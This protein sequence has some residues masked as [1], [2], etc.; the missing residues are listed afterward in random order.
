M[1][2]F[3]PILAS[4]LSALILSESALALPYEAP[5]APSLFKISLPSSVGYV[6]ETYSPNPSTSGP[7]PD[8]ILIQN[9][10][11]NRSV[12]FAIS[13]ILQ[14]L[15]TQGMMPDRIAVEGE[16]GPVDLTSM[17]RYPD[18][19]LRKKASDYL[20]QQGEMPG[21]MH[22]A[23]SDGAVGLY[24]IETDSF[25]QANL[26]M[27][28]ESYKG[29]A[30]LRSEIGKI[31]AVLPGLKRDPEVGRKAA[32][33]EKDLI[34][35]RQLID[36]QVIP[37][38]IPATLRQAHEAIAHLPYV[39]PKNQSQNVI[40]SLAASV[41]F[42]SLA[43]LRDEEMFKNAMIARELDNPK[44]SIIVTGGFH[45]HAI[46]QQLKQRGLSY[47]VI[48]PEVRSHTAVDENLYIARLMDQHLTPQQVATGRDWA[49][50]QMM[51][52]VYYAGRL[53]GSAYSAARSHRTGFLAASIVT[54]SLLSPSLLA[55]RVQPSDIVPQQ[56]TA[57]QNTGALA[58]QPTDPSAPV[59]VTLKPLEVK[60]KGKK[61]EMDLPPD[62]FQ[63][64]DGA[65]IAN[66]FLEILVAF[67]SPF[68]KEM[69]LS[70]GDLDIP[71]IRVDS[72]KDALSVD[73]NGSIRVDLYTLP[74]GDLRIRLRNIPLPKKTKLELKAD[75]D[76]TSDSNAGLKKVVVSPP[77][78]SPVTSPSVQLPR[79]TPQIAKTLLQRIYEFFD[80]PLEAAEQEQPFQEQTIVLPESPRMDKSYVYE[81]GV[82]PPDF[83]PGPNGYEPE[84]FLRVT[85]TTPFFNFQI[86][87]I[88]A[89]GE[90]ETFS[91]R[92]DATKGLALPEDMPFFFG[93]HVGIYPASDGDQERGLRVMFR[94]FPPGA[95]PRIR[96]DVPAKVELVK[97]TLA[98]SDQSSKNTVRPRG[99]ASKFNLFPF[100]MGVIGF[101][102]K[103]WRR[104][105]LSPET[106]FNPQDLDRLRKSLEG[107]P[108]VLGI[109][110]YTPN[111]DGLPHAIAIRHA[112]HH[113]TQ[114]D[115]Q[116]LNQ[117]AEQHPWIAQFSSY[118]LPLPVGRFESDFKEGFDNILLNLVVRGHAADGVPVIGPHMVVA[119]DSRRQE[120][121][122]RLIE[123]RILKAAHE[124]SIHHTF[125]PT[126]A[127]AHSRGHIKRSPQQG[128]AS[129][130]GILVAGLLSL[131]AL[132]GFPLLTS[133]SQTPQTV[134]QQAPSA[135]PPAPL[136][137][138]MHLEKF[139]EAGEDDAGKVYQSEITLEK[140][141]VGKNG[142]EPKK[143][144]V[145]VYDALPERPSKKTESSRIGTLELLVHKKNKDTG[146]IEVQRVSS[147]DFRI[148][149]NGDLHMG[150]MQSPPLA[151]IVRNMNLKPV[152]DKAGRFNLFFALHT[153]RFVRAFETD[154]PEYTVEKFVLHI[155]VTSDT[156]P[157]LRWITT[158]PETT[159]TKAVGQV[160]I[161]PSS[162]SGNWIAG[163]ISG[164]FK[165]PVILLGVIF[166]AFTMARTR[167]S[168][169]SQTATMSTR[170]TSRYRAPV[171]VSLSLLTLLLASLANVTLVGAAAIQRP[172]K[173][174]ATVQQPA[175][176]AQDPGERAKQLMGSTDPADD[177][178]ISP[179]QIPP[180]NAGPV[181][182]HYER[183]VLTPN[184]NM[185]SSGRVGE[186]E[187]ERGF[188]NLSGIQYIELALIPKNP[189][190]STDGETF[191]LNGKPVE[192]T[193]RR[194]DKLPDG[195]PVIRILLRM[196]S[197]DYSR[198]VV[199]TGSLGAPAYVLPFGYKKSST[200]AI[201]NQASASAVKPLSV[202][203]AIASAAILWVMGMFSA[204]RTRSETRARV[205]TGLSRLTSSVGATLA[206]YAIW[207]SRG[208]RTIPFP[209]VRRR[210]GAML[211]SM[212]ATARALKTAA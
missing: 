135:T 199:L 195:R 190:T 179:E 146:V 130:T 114:A 175:P 74:N 156:A 70:I 78:G 99:S 118:A 42:Y 185:D 84:L 140:M 121:L 89:N 9:L 205:R 134:T 109:F 106:P 165:L 157:E 104:K 56:M 6:T 39:R 149:P 11:V 5:A 79:A 45:T 93:V 88:A 151:S 94:K 92:L 38:E 169:P 23:V 54:L 163:M 68:K 66:S 60:V 52:A 124:L 75:V 32:M 63:G 131:A 123:I 173:L 21:V 102:P 61:I 186:F 162:D 144:D 133:S 44:T 73:R 33:L 210:S 105:E 28:R 58:G 128:S 153:I 43:L 90:V 142:E 3:K 171:W 122:F 125:A 159:V 154:N 212:A 196:E 207:M 1:K 145:F 141:P 152:A 8:V 113:P 76:L 187:I 115:N 57:S 12:Q 24:G 172:P 55:N 198:D 62:L 87:V 77:P 47:A 49:A 35:V 110:L 95:R 167:R 29:R 103:G 178:G 139:S 7:A 174:K 59:L 204:G 117:L 119:L 164:M 194:L 182:E 81:G 69:T 26:Q 181:R 136:R 208:L 161:P 158:V 14:H 82:V 191:R 30:A 10:H 206:D 211:H 168:Q 71:I 129:F 188:S 65:P 111:P 27:F 72:P 177:P 2:S 150:G 127:G 20:V 64:E 86:E 18:P 85:P 46:A 97:R 17:Q 53:F 200:A 126:Y 120:N 166:A 108:D 202:P 132:S 51:E 147:A 184:R 96:I 107:H 40:D 15:K 160:A 22:F 25:Y 203:G 36:N 50:M 13:K 193:T 91:G 183:V 31:E 189:G 209:T 41:N 201:I 34:A 138:E 48:T 180:Y 170:S 98:P 143:L 101:S 176:I 37:D 67:K 16:T 80:R 197:W 192:V 155:H 137:G 112:A 4:V 83:M 116:Y 19:L 148:E 100:L